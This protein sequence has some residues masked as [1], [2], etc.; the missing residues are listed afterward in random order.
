MAD[1]NNK[2]TRKIA[3]VSLAVA[4]KPMKLSEFA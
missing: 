2:Y 4:I 3:R 1:S